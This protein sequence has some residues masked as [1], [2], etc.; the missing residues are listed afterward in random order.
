MLLRI[1]SVVA[2]CALV[3][4]G[5]SFADSFAEALLLPAQKSSNTAHTAATA[6]GFIYPDATLTESDFIETGVMFVYNNH[7][8]DYFDGDSEKLLNY[9]NASIDHNNQAFI[10]SNIGLK[11]VVSGLVYVNEDELWSASDAYTDRLHKLA[12]W[13]RTQTGQQLKQQHRYSYL[14]S[15]AGFQTSANEETMLGQAFVGDNVSWISPFNTSADSWLERTLAHEL[16]HNDGFKHANTGQDDHGPLIARF[17]AAGYQCGSHGSIMYVSGLRTE[18][19]FSDADIHIDQNDKVEGCGAVGE[20]NAAQVYRDLLKTTFANAQATFA[21]IQTTRPQTGVVS[22]HENVSLALEGQNIQFDIIFEGANAGDSINYVARQGSAG[23]DD[24]QSTI[25]FIVH[26]GIN[27]VYSVSIPTHTDNE[28]EQSETFELEL[29]Y[30]NGVSIDS[31]NSSIQASIFDKNDNAGYVES[32]TSAVSV[33]EDASVQVT[34]SSVGGKSSAISAS[35]PAGTGSIADTDGAGGGS[36][37]MFWSLLL[38]M[39]ISVQQYKK[40]Q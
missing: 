34:I 38:L 15:L 1:K 39:V 4:A 11:R 9:V 27:N 32:T 7:I 21:N 19:F 14:V 10:N 8:L 29:V 37:N 2:I 3:L 30:P 40:Y 28:D 31:I 35:N 17:D 24:F 33:E 16:S 5:D 13:Q 26:D 20:A 12:A 36:L 23:L 18:P 22:I 25:G 6:T